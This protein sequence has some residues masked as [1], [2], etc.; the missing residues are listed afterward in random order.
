MKKKIIFSFIILVTILLLTLAIINPVTV[1]GHIY[2]GTGHGACGYTYSVDTLSQVSAETAFGLSW[3]NNT[4]Y[5]CVD[6][7]AIYER[8]ECIHVLNTSS[9]NGVVL[10]LRAILDISPDGSATIQYRQNGNTNGTLKTA[11]LPSSSKRVNKIAAYIA[12]WATDYDDNNRPDGPKKDCCATF[13]YLLFEDGYGQVLKTATG[14]VL[15]WTQDDTSFGNE[16]GYYGGTY[17]NKNLPSYPSDS[18]LS[19]SSIKARLMFYYGT[20]GEQDRVMLWGRT[21]PSANVKIDKYISSVNSSAVSGRS[22][23]TDTWKQTNAKDVE[24]GSASTITYTIKVKNEG[25]SAITGKVTDTFDTGYLSKTGTSGGSC[26]LANSVN[27]AAGAT[28]TY[29]LTLN[30]DTSK[31]TGKYENTATFTPNSGADSVSSSDWVN[32]VPKKPRIDKFVESA[33][34]ASIPSSRAGRDNTSKFSD[35]VLCGVVGAKKTITYKVKVENPNPAK[36][37][38]KF[39]DSTSSTK[40]TVKSITY[41]KSGETQTLSNGGEVW[42]PVGSRTFTVTAELAADAES[43]TYTNTATFTCLPAYGSHSVS[44]ADYIKVFDPPVCS[45]EKYVTKI[46]SGYPNPTEADNKDYGSTRA[47]MGDSEQGDTKKSNDPAVSKIGKVN[48]TYKIIV[49]NIGK[50]D[51]TG[52]L[53]DN[54]G[55]AFTGSYSETVTIPVGGSKEFTVTLGLNGS[56]NNTYTNTAYFT[57]NTPAGADPNP[58]SSSDYVRIDP[59]DPPKIDKSITQIGE[60]SFSRENL[61]DTYKEQNPASAGPVA[62]AITKTVSYKVVIQNNYDFSI[63]GKF[64]DIADSGINLGKFYNGTTEIANGSNVT[65]SAGSSVTI[66]FNATI[67]ATIEPGLYGNT[68][69][70]TFT[71]NSNYILTSSDYFE[72]TAPPPPPPSGSLKKYISNIENS[73]GSFRT[74]RTSMDDTTKNRNP[75]EVI[76]GSIVEFTVEATANIHFTNISG[77][78]HNGNRCP[79]HYKNESYTLTCVDTYDSGLE[80]VSCEGAGYSNGTI[81]W[82]GVKPNPDVNTPT[83]V[84]AKLKFKVTASNMTL[85]NLRNNVSDLKYSYNE[86]LCY[87]VHAT[88]E[89]RGS[90]ELGEYNYCYHNACHFEHKATPHSGDLGGDSSDYV[91]LLDPIISGTVFL[92]ED[93]NNLMDGNYQ[94]KNMTREQYKKITVELVNASD[95]KTVATELVNPDNGTYSFGRVR[96]GD[97]KDGDKLRDGDNDYAHIGENNYFY[98][99]NATLLH[100]YLI[101]NYDGERY[102]AVVNAGTSN[103]DATTHAM[104]ETFKI[105]SNADE[106]DREVFNSRLETNSNNRAFQNSTGEEPSNEVKYELVEG[107]DGQPKTKLQES[108]AFWNGDTGSV[109]NLEARTFNLYFDDGETE[110]LQYINLGLRERER[111]NLKLTK[112]VIDATV[113]V[114][115]FKTTYTFDKFGKDGEKFYVDSDSDNALDN[116]YT[117]RIYREDY[118]YRTDRQPD[119]VK[120]IL[121]NNNPYKDYG[122]DNDLQILIR[123]RITVTNTSATTKAVV[124]EIVDYYSS[125]MTDCGATLNGT[126]LTS[127]TTSKFRNDP[128]ACEGGSRVFYNG[129][130]LDSTTIEPNKSIEIIATYRVNKSEGYIV[131]D[132]FGNTLFDGK[133]NVAEVGAYSFYEPLAGKPA[134][135]ID[136]NSNPANITTSEKGYNTSKFEDDT[137]ATGLLV[138]L[139]DEPPETPPTTPEERR[140]KYV[141]RNISGIVFE[142]MVENTNV[143]DGQKVGD[144][145]MKGDDDIPAKNVLVKLYEVVRD[146]TNEYL[147]DTGLWYRTGTDG[148]YYFGDGKSV[149]DAK[150]STNDMYKLHAGNYVVRFIYGDEA[151]KFFIDENVDKNKKPDYKETLKYSGQ[152]FKSAKY[153]QVGTNDETEILEADSFSKISG[154]TNNYVGDNINL[155]VGPNIVSVAKD[156]EVRRL[157]VNNYSTTMTYPMDTVLKAQ[158]GETE[159]L[160]VLAANTSMFA[161]TKVFK[162]DVEYVENYTERDNRIIDGTLRVSETTSDNVKTII[163]KYN[164]SVRDVNFG[165][166]E[167]PKTKLQLMNDI[168]E[169]KAITSDGNT[170]LDVFF[171]VTYKRNEDGT[172][173]HTVKLNTDKSIGNENVQALDRTPGSQGFRYANIDS[174]ILQ[175]LNITI[176]FQIAVANIGDVDH[177]S[178]DLESRIENEPYIDLDVSYKNQS[179]GANTAAGNNTIETNGDNVEIYSYQ[180]RNYNRGRSALNNMLY[181]SGGISSSLMDNNHGVAGAYNASDTTSSAKYVKVGSDSV[182]KQYTYTNL[183]TID[184]GYSF[185]K[186]VGNIYY[187]NVKGND[188]QVKTRVD[189]FVDYVDNDLVFKPEE[190]VNSENKVQYLTYTANEIAKRGLLRDVTTETENISDSKR[191]YYNS[192]NAQGNNN[193]AFNI[194]DNGVNGTFYRFLPVLTAV[195]DENVSETNLYVLGLQASKLLSSELD[196]EGVEI[197]NLAEIVKVANTVGRK[198]YVRD[199]AA[200]DATIGITHI[201]NTTTQITTSH[202]SMN[203]KSTTFVDLSKTE[204]D[205]DFTEYVTFSPPTGLSKAQRTQNATINALLII[206]PSLIIVAG[207]SYV[208]VQLIKRKKFYK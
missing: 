58:K 160:S 96:K 161:D 38:G 14:G 157:E 26:T 103:L 57:I 172:V 115:G 194:E 125:E 119:T 145:V 155:G 148:R 191:D 68:S 131:K 207:V 85:P 1:F 187:T 144:G 89:T 208:A 40:L 126:S 146:G 141:Y 25:S 130:N 128:K 138:V 41:Q 20:G 82:T 140:E 69:K 86:Y 66:T 136:N 15:D 93:G 204:I 104:N 37:K 107:A 111:A 17:K 163:E 10:T 39:S 54:P 152:D 127:T 91:R 175:G 63:T 118:E 42:I 133:Y 180:T 12:K 56:A 165:L 197:E 123:Y 36:I 122:R 73:P 173:E 67:S 142:D 203:P 46:S 166:I 178:T 18:Q 11:T 158:P 151:D 201:G 62:E 149:D 129:G 13:G 52:T 29:T 72:I 184:S 120:G 28:K 76:K 81:T 100:Y 43:G 98:Y 80:F 177:I 6:N 186:Y 135:L 21:A 153:T 24:A 169:I 55:G 71:T 90:V 106:V 137:F 50:I 7:R 199:D 8:E 78:D 70:F 156:N 189:Q 114:N 48:V 124:R 179:S 108:K 53:T 34:D 35:P 196:L 200:R 105:D 92:D 22:S 182:S 121:N 134:G 5:I 181:G 94:I 112:D 33:T 185:G 65:I 150:E 192:K 75:G 117:L 30:C 9:D 116:P 132:L 88:N 16:W 74:G 60:T 23:K 31:T 188:T 77:V 101:F 83:T 99:N 162:M 164:Y 95:N 170:L 27:I 193:L 79:E 87:I 171:D 44:S 159:E 51:F 4:K 167:R 64:E 97:N 61:E 205:T 168:T 59:Y 206:I 2:G 45:I 47:G 195:A 139:R 143:V 109:L 202:S 154:N 102:V 84:T 49:K 174:E 183:K 19:S 147:V 190:N 110:Y 32:I 113:T 176:K 198:V 3:N